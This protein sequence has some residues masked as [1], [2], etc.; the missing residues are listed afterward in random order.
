MTR[1]L[2]NSQ[3]H[4]QWQNKLTYLPNFRLAASPAHLT[5]PEDLPANHASEGEDRQEAEEQQTGQLPAVD[6]GDDDADADVAE[7]L[8][9]HADSHSSHL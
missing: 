4:S 8:E 9:D 6:E 3:G 2:Y 7:D 5:P 1:S